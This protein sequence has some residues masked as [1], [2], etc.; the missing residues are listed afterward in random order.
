[1]FAG[2]LS[3]ALG[4]LI[5][6]LAPTGAWFWVGVPFGALSGLFSP[7][8]QGI[9]TK[10]VR[11][12]EQGQLQGANSSVQGIC[13]M[14]GPGL[15]TMVLAWSIASGTAIQGAPFFLAGGITLA[16]L[17]LALWET[18]RAASAEAGAAAPA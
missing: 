5:Y 18:R 4:S 17:V 9:M 1:M 3:A 10:R 6:G 7:A 13:G 15:F 11:A 12:D 14:I 8:V 2:L 16:A